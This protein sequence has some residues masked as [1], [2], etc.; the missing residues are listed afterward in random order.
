MSADVSGGRCRDS[1]LRQAYPGCP[2]RNRRV[3][4]RGGAC[5]PRPRRRTQTAAW[6]RP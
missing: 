2:L 6:S 3:R 5:C 1:G 4:R